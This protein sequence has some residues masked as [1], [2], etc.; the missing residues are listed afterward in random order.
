MND[1]LGDAGGDGGKGRG[2]RKNPA[3]SGQGDVEEG[4]EAP[5]TE[6]E[7]AMQQFFR[8]VEDIKTDMAEIR[9]LQRDVMAMHEKSKT[10]VK[11]KEM[12]KHRKE[13]QDKINQVSVLAHK[14]KTKV[15][16]LDK[17][18]EEAKKV[19]GQGEGT[20]GERTRT[21]ITAG[22]KKKLKDLMGEFSDLRN[23]I[24][25]E[26]REVVERRVYTVTGQHMAEDDI[27]RMIETG[28]AE[29]IFQKAMLEQGRGRVLD[30][31]AEIQERHR[32]VKDLEQ[33]LLELHQ[34]F[35][36]MAVLVEA[37]GEMLDNIEKQVARSV[38]Y[39]QGGTQALQD[40]KQL[41]KKT[42]KMM[43]CALFI[44][45]IVALIIVLAVVQPW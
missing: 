1:L 18:N 20:A 33:S 3:Y 27:D 31:L 23:T 38:E 17:Q 10:I 19:K 37:Q 35:L 9:G 44:V 29:N 21:T 16:A 13:M 26:Y 6:Q 4:F 45:L 24:Q 42:R 15:E 8:S 41:Q 39:V 28:E 25:D 14:V 22:L 12:E 40:A 43:C 30:T 2:G 36:D 5:P 7:M 34:I 32:A 11:S